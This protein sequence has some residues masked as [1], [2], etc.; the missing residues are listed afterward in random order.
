M[1]RHPFRILFVLI[2]L[3]VGMICTLRWRAWFDMPD[4]PLWEGDTIRHEFVILDRDWTPDSLS[5]L[6]LGDVHN[7]LSRDEWVRLDTLCP[8]LDGYLQVGDFV[9]RPYFYYFQ[10][11]YHQFDST[12]F[13]SLPLLVVPGNHEYRKGLFPELDARWLEVFPMPQNGP[14]GYH[15]CSYYVDLPFVR[16][17]GM[18]TQGLNHLL[19]YTRHLHWLHEVIDGA[20]GR[21]VVVM[22]HH[23]VYS[24]AKGRQNYMIRL[25]FS[26]VLDEADLV[27]SGHDHVYCR[28]GHYVTTNIST[29]YYSH[30]YPDGARNIEGERLYQLLEG[31]RDTLR[32]KMYNLETGEL[33][34]EFVIHR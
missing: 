2:L 27:I 29:K 30:T 24:A 26:N 7:E 8:D 5:L 18:D 13:D 14:V 28:R 34:D 19:D 21:Y 23:P 3:A 31:T 22:M 1:K 11:L 9:E 12:R 4:E 15:G 6:V 16:I 25:F 32:W 10:Q 33:W 17:I 20:E